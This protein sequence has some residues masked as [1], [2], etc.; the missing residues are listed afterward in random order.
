ML[1]VAEILRHRQR[2]VPHAKPGTRRLV[3]LAE[4]HDHVW[5]HGGFLHRLSQL[6]A[7]T[8]AFA[9]AAEQAD[10]LMMTDHV[11]DH[12]GEQNGSADAGATEQTG[13]APAFQR[14][15][16]VDGLDTRLKDFRSGRAPRERRR[17]LL[18][19]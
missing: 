4:D 12:L 13:L 18:N 6:L 3:H 5:K 15:Q 14:Y 8:T 19:P 1:V 10:A 2:R 11:V 9:N 17:C 7:F 16:N